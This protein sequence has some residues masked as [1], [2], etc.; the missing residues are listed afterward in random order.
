MFFTSLPL[1]LTEDVR[2]Q[3]LDN[4]D[5]TIDTEFLYVQEACTRAATALALANLAILAGAAA[6]K[7]NTR[8]VLSGLLDIAMFATVTIVLVDPAESRVLPGRIILGLT[9]IKLVIHAILIPR[10]AQAAQKEAHVSFAGLLREIPVDDLR[11]DKSL[12]KD[13]LLDKLAMLD[14]WLSIRA[15]RR[16][17]NLK[18]RSGH[19]K[20]GWLAAFTFIVCFGVF[21]NEY[22]AVTSTQE[23]YFTDAELEAMIDRS[24]DTFP[25]T[26]SHTGSKVLV[27]VIDGLR[28]DFVE[29][30]D[31][32]DGRNPAFTSLINDFSADMTYRSMQA[33][34]PSMSVPNWVTILTG[35][36]PELHGV[37]GNLFVPETKFDNIYKLSKDLGLNAMLSGSPWWSDLV[38]S[39]LPVL[40][41]DGTIDA[42][43]GSNGEPT[44]EPSDAIRVNTTLGAI[45]QTGGNEY[46][47]MLCHFSDVD[48]Q[49][50]SFGV[51][52]EWNTD[53]TYQNAVTT[54]VDLTRQLMNAVDNDTTVVIV[55]DHGHV[56]RGG[57]GGPD[58]G[59]LAVPVMFYKRN[60]NIGADF[61][62]TAAEVEDY[63]FPRAINEPSNVDI[64]PSVAALLGLPM[65]RT[66]LGVPLPEAMALVPPAA[67]ETVL[68]DVYNQKKTFFAA[69]ASAEYAAATSTAGTVYV[70][71]DEAV[72]GTFIETVDAGQTNWSAVRQ[73]GLYF[74]LG[75]NL[76]FAIPV[77][78][79]LMVAVG[80]AIQ[81][82]TFADLRAVS[83]R[84]S[85]WKIVSKSSC[86]SKNWYAALY[87]LLLVMV[88]HAF[89]YAAYVVLYTTYG[90]TIDQAVGSTVIH[91]PSAGPRYFAFALLPST[92]LV[93]VM[94]RLVQLPFIKLP[95]LKES[96]LDNLATIL[97][98]TNQKY[99]KADMAYLTDV[100][101][102]YWSAASFTIEFVAASTFTFILPWMFRI[103]YIVPFGWVARFQVLT[104]L[105]RTFP[106]LVM[107]IRNASAHPEQ[108]ASNGTD[109]DK[110][111][112]L[113]A[114]K[115]DRSRAIKRVNEARKN[116]RKLGQ[117]KDLVKR[118]MKEAADSTPPS[119]TTELLLPATTGQFENVDAPGDVFKQK[120]D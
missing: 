29:G 26:L 64:A 102:L 55:A 19:S 48:K 42:A 71:M 17:Y 107:S 104:L 41:G 57:H 28:Y 38:A 67:R 51:D 36:P 15:V 59:L 97:L 14:T 61:D 20:L 13:A 106:L 8:L 18:L 69:Y 110:I 32:A 116:A 56:E 53:D 4:A 112:T 76:L 94:Q 37:I 70:E 82:W 101:L 34:L 84:S 1:A 81:L 62:L 60:S 23:S 52:T 96:P 83:I 72:N 12:T 63:G 90:Y 78:W 46:Q 99:N 24:A 119:V 80:L 45:A 89:A 113:K 21:I 33:S 73:R 100:W 75:R 92:A 50:H 65:P 10:Q 49:G 85:T 58:P 109:M 9:L 103:I 111:Y 87:S 68:Q 3:E 47:F 43:F 118:S 91:T 25:S 35:A 44:S 11:S 86:G 27:V 95:L 77:A 105:L 6:A 7:S 88:Y 16:K 2:L 120:S 31:G 114:H 117:D 108:V 66:A 115:D 74:L 5:S 22:R 54:K 30:E 93:L 39:Q 79:V 40:A 98:G